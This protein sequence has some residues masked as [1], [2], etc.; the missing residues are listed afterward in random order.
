MKYQDE[1]QEKVVVQEHLGTPLKTTKKELNR[2]QKF[3]AFFIP[4]LKFKWE[5]GERMLEATIKEQEANAALKQAEAIKT[6]AEAKTIEADRELKMKQI[7][8]A[9][10]K[11]E[12]KKLEAYE[13]Q[14]AQEVEFTEE[15]IQ[16]KM[17]ELMEKMMMLR[18]KKG[19][20]IEVSEE[21]MEDIVRDGLS[22]Y[23]DVLTDRERVVVIGRYRQEKSYKEIAADLE[24][25]TDAVK[26]IMHRV[27]S[28][29]IE[30]SK[31]EGEDK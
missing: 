25:S 17:E 21:V 5:Q 1:K 23:L 30:S 16:D 3:V 12:E 8:A 10:K 14:D 6:I 20:Q 26:Q 31:E 2:W 22:K 19:T 29:M 11:M 27:K 13:I 9:A 4:H 28:K 24:L 7:V 18:L 15:E